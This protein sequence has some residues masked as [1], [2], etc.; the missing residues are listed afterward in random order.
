MKSRTRSYSLRDRGPIVLVAID[1]PGGAGKSSLAATLA[2]SLG[3]VTVAGDDF[4]RALRIQ[5]SGS[6][7]DLEGGYMRYIDWERLRAQVLE[8]LREGRAARYER[9]DWGLER[10]GAD[11][12]EVPASGVILV[13]GVYSFRSELRRFYDWSILVEAPREE[14]FQRMRARGNSEDWI[15]RWDAAEQW[16]FDNVFS[17][18]DVDAVVSGT[19]GLGEIVRCAE[20]KFADGALGSVAVEV[21]PE[22]LETVE[23]WIELH[24]SKLGGVEVVADATAIVLD[25]AYVHRWEWRA[26]QRLG[27]GWTQR[28]R[29]RIAAA[30]PQAGPH[31]SGRLDGGQIEALEATYTNM[32]PVPLRIAGSVRLQI[33]TVRWESRPAI[34]RRDRDRS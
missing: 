22:V 6:R 26:G 15:Q 16:Y 18:G 20:P 21:V 7:L 17:R 23:T 8:P 14:R 10:I 24:D 30:I 25:P 19:Q 34:R 5:R 27:T 12:V 28:A 1:G 13:E 31:D 33:G 29:L 3:A 4:Y 2:R 32:I 9:F 11:V